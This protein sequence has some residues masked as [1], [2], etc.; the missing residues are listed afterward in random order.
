MAKLQPKVYTIGLTK[1]A[2]TLAR[3]RF[4]AQPAIRLRAAGWGAVGRG[5]KRVR[6]GDNGSIRRCYARGIF[7]SFPNDFKWRANLIY[8]HLLPHRCNY[9]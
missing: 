8:P 9:R 7:N 2:P 4:V 1:F 3:V 6:V 5:A